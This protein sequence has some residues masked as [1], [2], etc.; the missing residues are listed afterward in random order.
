MCEKR[1]EQFEFP[2]RAAMATLRRIAVGGDASEELAFNGL[3]TQQ[4]SALP[5]DQDVAVLQELV[6]ITHSQSARMERF[7]Y[8]VYEEHVHAQRALTVESD[9]ER[10]DAEMAAEGFFFS[11]NA[12]PL[13]HFMYQ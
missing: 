11:D 2:G 3:L 10:N 13:R 7:M 9:W 4:L 1:A 6:F 5:C 12:A 8:G